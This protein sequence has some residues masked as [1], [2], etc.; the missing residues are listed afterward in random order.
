[1]GRE[2]VSLF[3]EWASTYDE[4]VSGSDVEYKEVF[5]GYEKILEL[6]AEGSKGNVLE[7]GVGTGNLTEKLL[8]AGHKVYGIEPSKGMREIAEKRFPKVEIVDGDFIDFPKPNDTIHSIVSSYAFHHLTDEEK[9]KAIS[10]YRDILPVHGRVVFADTVYA[11]EFSKRRMIAE[12][13]KNQYHHLLHDLQTEYY[14]TIDVLS[15]MFYENGF[16]VKFSQCN[17]FVW[18]I[19]AEKL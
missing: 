1:M 7:F 8:E 17:P 12:A 13:E 10:V 3:D 19:Q 4:S 2:F 9:A 18:L 15:A 14:T 11:G 5:S 16:T 6:V